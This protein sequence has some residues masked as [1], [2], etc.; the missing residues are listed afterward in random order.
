MTPLLWHRFVRDARDAHT[1]CMAVGRVAIPQMCVLVGG[2]IVGR[3]MLRP[4]LTG[5]D[6]V[7]GVAE[8]SH[9]AAA[10]SADEIVAVWEARDLDRAC[11]GEIPTASRGEL[12]I[13]T[14]TPDGHILFRYP[15]KEVLLPERTSDGLFMGRPEWLLPS[16]G[17]PDAELPPAIDALVEF[18][19][20]PLDIDVPKP[21]LLDYTVGYL[22]TEGYAIDLLRRP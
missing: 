16:L 14:A 22:R 19:W 10:V 11:G 5:S 21:N 2:D 8:M 3:V 18:C 12:D 13:L 15:Y 17:E 1:S 4:I 7:M 9:L 6:A 20:R